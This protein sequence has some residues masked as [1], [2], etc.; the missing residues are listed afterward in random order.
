MPHP[1]LYRI[2]LAKT[3]YFESMTSKHTDD[4]R[5][6]DLWSVPY[7]RSAL[8][9]RRPAS[10]S[11]RARGPPVNMEPGSPAVL[12]APTL[13]KEIEEALEPNSYRIRQL[14]R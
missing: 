1:A 4:P 14:R 5:A 13:L 8:P 9:D 10:V 3:Q 12:Y 6:D 2:K 7:S 11:V